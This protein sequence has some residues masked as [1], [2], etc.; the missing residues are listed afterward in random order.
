MTANSNIDSFPKLT[1]TTDPLAPESRLESYCFPDVDIQ[2]FEQLLSENPLTLSSDYPYQP[3][4]EVAVINSLQAD[5]ALTQRFLFGLAQS[6]DP[7]IQLATDRAFLLPEMHSPPTDLQNGQ[8]K[9]FGVSLRVTSEQLPTSTTAEELAVGLLAIFDDNHQPIGVIN[10]HP[11]SINLKSSQELRVPITTTGEIF[12]HWLGHSYPQI[13][14]ETLT[15]FLSEHQQFWSPNSPTLQRLGLNTIN[16]SIIP[17]ESKFVIWQALS[18]PSTVE[19]MTNSISASVRPLMMAYLMATCIESPAQVKNFIQFI[20]RIDPNIVAKISQQII[21]IT[22]QESSNSL[23]FQKLV[24]SLSNL[25]EHNQPQDIANLAAASLLA[26]QNFSSEIVSGKNSSEEVFP[27]LSAPNIRLSLMRGLIKRVRDH[28]LGLASTPPD[29]PEYKFAQSGLLAHMAFLIG[30]NLSLSPEEITS[31]Y[32]PPFFWREFRQHY[33]SPHA[34]ANLDSLLE[35]WQ[36]LYIKKESLVDHP[37]TVQVLADYYTHPVSQEVLEAGTQTG[38]T[39]TEILRQFSAIDWLV[40]HGHLKSNSTISLFDWGPY[41]GKRILQPTITYL[42][43]KHGITCAWSDGTV[44][45][46]AD[47]ITHPDTIPGLGVIN[48]SFSTVLSA[49]PELKGSADLATISWS[50]DVDSTTLNER[51]LNALAYSNVLKPQGILMIETSQPE[52]LGG[53]DELLRQYKDSHPDSPEGTLDFK[54]EDMESSDAH[55]I[56]IL[57]WEMLYKSLTD[58]GLTPLNI[59]SELS[60]RMKLFANIISGNP[61]EN[62]Q[63]DPFI[64]PGWQASRPRLNIIARKTGSPDMSPNL[65]VARHSKQ[66]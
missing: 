10:I 1:H 15:K 34:Q 2:T 46:G 49:K 3:P 44:V 56:T 41:T 45:Y 19:I 38:N 28:A 48:S 62:G 39:Q 8:F 51:L 42:K 55:R 43:E 32:L 63:F 66:E 12:Q 36:F 53:Y 30:L 5:K 9:Y 33:D 50:S 27:N 26:S 31:S 37:Q 21:G 52:G 4:W 58:V 57:Y 29:S 18:D 6:P 24:T 64:S 35:L 17:L 59:P 14:Q 25:L 16:P 20:S 60:E 47:A 7:R 40:E 61:S 11:Y 54:F 13:N 65:F 23:S 22:L